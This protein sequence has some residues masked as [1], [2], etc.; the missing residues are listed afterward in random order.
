MAKPE[1]KLESKRQRFEILR[2]QLDIERSSFMPQWRDINDF[3][4]P[5][6]GKFFL[7][8]NN[9]GD[10]RNL[11][12]INNAGTLAANTLHAGMMSGT[13]S[14]SRPW[15]RLA[16]PDPDLNEF[17]AVKNWTNL[18]ADRMPANRGSV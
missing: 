8:D 15:F 9:K 7:G 3:I 2:S 1:P 6:S 17:G 12:I 14:P 5:S 4:L 13:M 10:R 11:K 18:V 16:S